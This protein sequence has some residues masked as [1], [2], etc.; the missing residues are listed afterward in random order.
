MSAGAQVDE[1]GAHMGFTGKS[2]S[3]KLKKKKDKRKKKKKT[4]CTTFYD[5]IDQP[6]CL[7]ASGWSSG[8]S[9]KCHMNRCNKCS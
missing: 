3:A 8:L 7:T 6:I 1:G 5:F 2:A 9:I 4:R